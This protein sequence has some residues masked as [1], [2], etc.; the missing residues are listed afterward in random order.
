M[1][2]FSRKLVRL[3]MLPYCF[4]SAISSR[5]KR[6]S[7]LS[8]LSQSFQENQLMASWHQPLLHPPWLRP[9]SSP[10]TNMGVP[11]LR[12][13]ATREFRICFSR[14]CRMCASPVSP[15]TPQFQELLWSSPLFSP[16]Q[17]F[18]LLSYDTKSLRVKPSWAVMKLM[19]WN[20][21]RPLCWKR[22]ELPQTL[23]AKSPFTPPSPLMKRRTV[24][25][26]IPFHSAQRGGPQEG[27]LPT[28]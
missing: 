15:S 9:Y 1:S 16:L 4:L 12:K 26:N 8:S 21:P 18:F 5:V 25:R 27:N 24:S 19:E 20:G 11:A 22:S 13:R 2:F 6:N 7:L 28:R 23:V 10:K 17:V 3:K 14:R